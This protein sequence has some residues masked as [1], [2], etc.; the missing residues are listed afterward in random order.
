MTSAQCQQTAEDWFNKGAA[1]GSLGNYNEEKIGSI[2]EIL[3]LR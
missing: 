1:L 2:S 3:A